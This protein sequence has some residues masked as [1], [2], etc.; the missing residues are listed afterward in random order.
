MILSLC[1]LI[2]GAG[3]VLLEVLFPSFGL[4]G[5]AAVAAAGFAVVSAFQESE[6]GG[7]LILGLGLVL[8]PLAVRTGLGLLPRTPMGRRLMLAPPAQRPDA[9]AAEELAGS[10]GVALTDLRPA[11]A[12]LLRGERRDVVTRGGFVEEGRPVRVVEVE[13]PRIVVEECLPPGDPGSS[14]SP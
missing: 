13:G 6:G 11:G 4:L 7:W 2:L 9:R 1:L 8:L 14:V 12:A 5:L 3:L 10:E